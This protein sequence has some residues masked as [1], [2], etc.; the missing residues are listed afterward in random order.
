M[1]AGPEVVQRVI[2]A[3]RV[4]AEANR[5]TATRTGSVVVLGPAEAAEVM[6]TADLHGQRLNFLKLCR[7]ASLADHPQ[8]HLIAQEA[9]HGGPSYPLGNGCM[10]HL[11]L[12]DMAELKQRFPE[13]FH[14]LLSNHELAEWTEFPIAK[15]GRV[16]NLWFR[17][18][19]QTMYG[20]AAVAVRAAMI[21]FLATCPLAVR[22]ANRIFICHGSPAHVPER[23]F[24]PDFLQRA[25]MAADL[26][27]GSDAFRMLWGR[28][29][30]PENAAALADL[31]DADILIHGHEP[32]RQG[33][34]TPN[35]RQVIL[36]CSGRNARYLILPTGQPLTHAE[37]VQRIQRLHGPA[38]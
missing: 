21:E 2:T 11:L 22:L 23:G 25:L 36:D 20:E 30:R 35:E 32:C 7:I 37:V 28:D 5:R 15:G 9:C 38:S 12:E 27:S 26:R 24:A 1:V 13:R 17:A 4:A 18:G 31:L 8:R 6:I 29:F 34:A 16:L 3:Y 33:F 14:F 19:L 10:S